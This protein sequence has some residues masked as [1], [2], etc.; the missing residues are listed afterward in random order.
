MPSWLVPETE[1]FAHKDRFRLKLAEQHLADEIVRGPF[2]RR[3]RK[4][5]YQYLFDAAF[6]HDARALRGSGHHAGGAVWRNDANGVGVEGHR[7]GAPAVRICVFDD[8]AN[9]FAMPGVDSVEISDGNGAR[10]EVRG[11]FAQ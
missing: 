6:A 5:Q 3:F 8:A 1:I 7:G 9:E 4:R 2:R 10:S 11:H